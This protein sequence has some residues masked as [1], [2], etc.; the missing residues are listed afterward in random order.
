MLAIDYSGVRFGNVVG[1]FPTEKR[2]HG[3]VVWVWKCD[4]GMEFNREARHFVETGAGQCPV[5]TKLKMRDLHKK[6]GKTR[7]KVYRAWRQVRGRC[8][9]PN[10]LC[11]Y[12]YG[13]KGITI[14]SCLSDSFEEFY[15]ELGDPPD[16]N[17]SW[18]VGRIDNSKGYEKGNIRWES[19]LQQAHNR[20]KFVT[21]TSGVTGVSLKQ[22]KG[23]AYWIAFWCD[24][25]KKLK[26][27]HF[28]IAKFGYDQAFE[29]ACDY[30]K[31]MISELTDILGED[32][33]AKDCGL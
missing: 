17:L 10:N 21:N 4:C 9:N 25:D 24:K 3:Q 22:D 33:Y 16:D 32:G 31:E 29:M 28:S 27:K 18:S 23:Y 2:R 6:H 5:C 14:E 30:R 15:K 7:T 20:G 1:R 19:P 8:L 26:S 13:G 11:Y 12:R